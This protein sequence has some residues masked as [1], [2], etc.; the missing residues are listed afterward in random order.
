MLHFGKVRAERM[1]MGEI[2]SEK[3]QI[4][5]VILNRQKL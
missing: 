1:V 5:N 3:H 4:S 2:I